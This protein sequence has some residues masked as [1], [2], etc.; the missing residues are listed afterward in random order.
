MAWNLIAQHLLWLASPLLNP[1]ESNIKVFTVFWQ[2]NNN[3][4]INNTFNVKIIKKKIVVKPIH[5]MWFLY[6]LINYE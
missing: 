5:I 3:K 2:L 4:N 6:F 1:S